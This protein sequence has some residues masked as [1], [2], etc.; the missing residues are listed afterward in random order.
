M[1]QFDPIATYRDYDHV[2]AADYL[3]SL[4]FPATARRMLFDVFARSFFNREE[5][6]SAAELLMMFHF[7]FFGNP[8]GL[9][10]DVARRPLSIGLW[11]PLGAYLEDRG[12]RFAFGEEVLEVARAGAGF[13]IATTERRDTHDACVLAL[14]VP[15]LK[16]LIAAST[17]L[18]APRLRTE[19]ASLDVTLPFVVWR[20]WLDAPTAPTRPPFAGTTGAGLIDN[21]S[22]FHRLEDESRAWAAV[23]GGAVVELHAYAVPADAD[24]DEIRRDLLA[25][26]HRLYP[27][28]RGARQVAERYMRGND[29]PAFTVGS[30]ALRPQVTTEI[31]CLVLA[32]DFVKLAVPSALMERAVMSGMIAANHLL[33]LRGISGAPIWSVPRRGMLRAPGRRLKWA[34]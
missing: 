14:S 7:Y 32:G 31:D 17:T 33:A 15:G 5:T 30:W 4:R 19:V 22:L 13:A 10:F 12:V 2:S 3:D 6:M 21:I 29:C 16:R 26:L 25:G 8:E 18:D 27:E 28:T 23:T 34:G 24:D 9:V 11:A 1:L 20:L